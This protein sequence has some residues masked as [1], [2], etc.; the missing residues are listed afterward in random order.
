MSE[1]TQ[2]KAIRCFDGW[3]YVYQHHSQTTNCDMEFAVYVP[4]Q[5]E[6]RDALPVIYF[7]SGLTCSWEN[8]ASKAG[9]QRYAAE[10]GAILVAPDTS[11][12][13]VDIEGEDE[14]YD[15]GSGAG[16]YVDALKQPWAQHYCM[17][18]YVTDELPALITKNF[19]ADSERQSIMGHSMGGHGALVCALHNPGLFKAVSAFAPVVNPVDVPWG[20]KAFHGYLGEDREYWAQYD[21]TRLVSADKWPRPILIDQ[22]GDDQFL[23][24]QLQP[25]IFRQACDSAGVDIT[26]NWREGYDHSYYF[27]ASFIGDHIAWHLHEES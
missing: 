16:F 21:A 11:P 17:Y 14:S 10:Y 13:G 22:G 15:F 1:L 4:P 9:A 20:K 8:F 6:T 7:L 25:E 19:P 27:I 26:L 12:R 23:G 5:A 2:N 24:E 18:S 3:Q